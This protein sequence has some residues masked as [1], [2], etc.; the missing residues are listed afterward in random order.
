MVHA[1]M[2]DGGDGSVEDL[3]RAAAGGHGPSFTLLLEAIYDRIYRLAWR[4]CGNVPDAEDIAQEIC[5]KLAMAIRDFRG[6]AG[7]LTWVYR[8]AYTTAVDHV[9]RRSRMEPFDPVDLAAMS[10]R[11][12][13]T[14]E[15]AGAEA[16][17]LNGELW[18]E[19]R[20]LPG[21]QRDAVLLVYGEDLS[22][23]EAGAVMGC[24]EKTV[25]WHL[26]EA[27]KRLRARLEVVG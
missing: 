27:R 5:V 2:N 25:S 6:E 17:V 11:S 20:G 23:A 15:A 9:R 18:A 19:V 26:H 12:M 16:H 3:A 24:S 1:T 22:H 21:Q 10:D 4:W 7:V 8:I 14:S 13:A